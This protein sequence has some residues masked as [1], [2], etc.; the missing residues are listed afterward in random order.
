[1]VGHAHARL[2]IDLAEVPLDLARQRARSGRRL[3][4]DRAPLLRRVARLPHQL[5]S[6]EAVIIVDAPRQLDAPRAGDLE[7]IVGR[8]E[9][10]A[11]RPIGLEIDA[12]RF[13]LGDAMR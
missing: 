2:Q 6:A 9:I 13:G 3:R 10:D 1:M 5:Y 4:F 12:V 8:I 7:R 11:R